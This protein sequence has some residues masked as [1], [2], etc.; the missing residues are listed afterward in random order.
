MHDT[1]LIR[2]STALGAASLAVFAGLGLVAAAPASASTVAKEHVR[3][4]AQGTYRAYLH[5]VP[6]TAVGGFSTGSATSTVVTPGHCVTIAF[7]TLGGSNEVKAIG[8]RADDSTFLVG[9]RSW[10]SRTGLALEARGTASDPRLK[11]S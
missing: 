3:L 1:K 4:C 9:T 10:N 5:I 2:R 6:R 7:D 8:V 11:T